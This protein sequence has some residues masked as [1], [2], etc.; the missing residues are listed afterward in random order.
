MESWR[1]T[2]DSSLNK[3]YY[4][5]YREWIPILTKQYHE[6]DIAVK[7]AIKDNV[8]KNWNLSVKLKDKIWEEIVRE[9]I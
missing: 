8:F 4:R 2:K 7:R 1:K 5:S 6:G 3:I 9:K